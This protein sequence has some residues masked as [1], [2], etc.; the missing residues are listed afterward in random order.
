MYIFP[1]CPFN[2]NELYGLL[3]WVGR[4]SVTLLSIQGI[5]PVTCGA[6]PD[7]KSESQTPASARCFCFSFFLVRLQP[8][9][10]L[11]ALPPCCLLFLVVDL[12]RKTA[13]AAR[14]SL[15]S[16]LTSGR[17]CATTTL[18]LALLMNWAVVCCVSS[19]VGAL[20][21]L[22]SP[23]AWCIYSKPQTALERFSERARRRYWRR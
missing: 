14:C 4:P 5:E 20:V 6:K 1:H 11:F 9:R 10:F 2:F 8:V 23:P 3:G 18:I 12:G 7:F 22:L 15:L 19:H 16:T 21:Q 13:I 17:P